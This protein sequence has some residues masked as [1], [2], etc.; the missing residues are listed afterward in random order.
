MKYGY[1]PYPDSDLIS[2]V[3][4]AKRYFDFME[5]TSSL[6]PSRYGPSQILGIR[7]VLGGYP[8]LGHVHWDISLPDD[9]ELMYKSIDFFIDIGAYAVTIHTDPN[10]GGILPAIYDYCRD[11]GID[12]LIENPPSKPYNVASR[13]RELIS[14]LPGIG[15][16]MDIG[17]LMKSPVG[18]LD[19]FMETF[20]GRIRHIHLH[21]S[22][23]GFDHLFFL[24]VDRLRRIMGKI[25][26]IG[27]HGT[28]TLE[29]A[30]IYVDGSLRPL[31]G[32]ER[33]SRLIE[34]LRL[35]KGIAESLG[36]VS[37]PKE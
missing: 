1:M 5:V 6:D 17:H 9:L 25:A 29:M 33:R 19:R 13:F 21:D 34:E 31:E 23:D 7:R 2:E 36:L 4:F 35:V 27:Y 37:Q 11:N 15:V 22:I 26:S 12:L 32:G 30:L 14:D 3:E 28:I 18:E 10:I 16:T 8:V 24:N 20:R